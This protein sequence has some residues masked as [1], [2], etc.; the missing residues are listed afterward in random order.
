MSVKSIIVKKI[1]KKL[2]GYKIQLN[3][4]NSSLPRNFGKR[5]ALELLVV[6]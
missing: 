2:G 1:E 4:V 5:K 3:K 6:G